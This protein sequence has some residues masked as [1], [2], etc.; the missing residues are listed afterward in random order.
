M[1]TRVC[2]TIEGLRDAGTG[3]SEQ[4]RLAG[5]SPQSTTPADPAETAD[6]GSSPPENHQD[7]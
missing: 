5:E 3:S 6:R 2:S 4:A 1:G 7:D